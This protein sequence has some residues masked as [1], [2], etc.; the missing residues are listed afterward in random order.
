MSTLLSIVV[1]AG[2]GLFALVAF[3]WIVAKLRGERQKLGYVSH[4]WIA[5]HAP[6]WEDRW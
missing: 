5:E 3:V 4:T 1:E 6:D 2:L